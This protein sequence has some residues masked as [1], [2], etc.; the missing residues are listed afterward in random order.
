MESMVYGCACTFSNFHL[1]IILDLVLFFRRIWNIS[2]NCLCI[3]LEKLTTCI[4]RVYIHD[5]RLRLMQ[6]A[7]I[8]MHFDWV[9]GDFSKRKDQLVHVARLHTI[10]L[11]TQISVK[12]RTKVEILLAQQIHQSNSKKKGD[13]LVYYRILLCEVQVGNVQAN[14]CIC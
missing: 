12:E 14:G 10:H 4:L 9:H 7:C 3:F 6:Y 8:E 11:C 13:A 1:N 2:Q 5:L